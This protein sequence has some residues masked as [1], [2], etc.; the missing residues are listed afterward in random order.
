MKKLLAI[1]TLSFSIFAF[2]MNNKS[3]KIEENSIS[4]GL[5]TVTFIL[6]CTGQSYTAWYHTMYEEGTPDFNRDLAWV[7]NVSVEEECGE[8]SSMVTYLY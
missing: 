3:E 1:C 5:Y 2:S 7:V 8:G 6:P 4:G